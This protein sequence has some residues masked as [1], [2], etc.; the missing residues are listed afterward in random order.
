VIASLRVRCKI[1]LLAVPLGI[2]PKLA[3]DG[4]VCPAAKTETI[5]QSNA[6]LRMD[7]AEAE[8]AP[9]RMRAGI[10]LSVLRFI[11]LPLLLLMVAE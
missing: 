6:E 1:S 4:F 11:F 10:D 3:E 9:A 7:P 2:L 5:N 8:H